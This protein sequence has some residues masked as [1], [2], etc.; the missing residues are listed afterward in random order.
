MYGSQR[1]PL[2]QLSSGKTGNVTN[3]LSATEACLSDGHYA[4]DMFLNGV[5][6]GSSV[7]DLSMGDLTV[8][9]SREVGV[10]GCLP[11][12]WERFG[13]SAK[14]WRPDAPARVF[15]VTEDG[16]KKFGA[17]VATF[18]VPSGLP[19]STYKPYF[20]RRMIGIILNKGLPDS[21][22]SQEKEDSVMRRAINLTDNEAS[23]DSDKRDAPLV[24]RYLYNPADK[25]VVRLAII[26]NV[27]APQFCP[28]IKSF[29]NYS[30]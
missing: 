9:R 26:G 23:C 17:A 3:V 20:L 14:G 29:A 12:A 30:E 1:S 7:A 10:V 18:Y 19:A 25:D 16:K 21:G 8:V 4:A 15:V 13:D 6:V 5:L 27:L 22:W 11:A 2:P 28:L 24:Y